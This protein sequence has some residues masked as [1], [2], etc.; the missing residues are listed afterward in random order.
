MIATC[1]H[2]QLSW[3]IPIEPLPIPYRIINNNRQY[4]LRYESGNDWAFMLP[5]AELSY[6]PAV[7]PVPLYLYEPSLPRPTPQARALREAVVT[8]IVR[9]R[10]YYTPRSGWYAPCSVLSEGA[11]SEGTGVLLRHLP[12]GFATAGRMGV[13]GGAAGSVTQQAG[14]SA[15]VGVMSSSRAGWGQWAGA[16]RRPQVAVV[17]DASL[18]RPERVMQCE[19]KKELAQEVSCCAGLCCLRVCCLCNAVMLCYVVHYDTV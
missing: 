5:V 10:S 9:R 6:R 18:E 17:G 7:L 13:Y 4:H 12:A 15:A 16:A 11:V 3:P 1:R 2:Y 19:E 14:A 8:E